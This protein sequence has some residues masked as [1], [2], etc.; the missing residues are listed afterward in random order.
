M[1][2]TYTQL[3]GLIDQA[4]L[5]RVEASLV[6]AAIAISV[7]APG[8]P[9]DVRRDALARNIMRESGL[10]ARN[11]A[12]AV[13]LGFTGG[14]NLTSVLDSAIDTRVA[15]VFNDFLSQT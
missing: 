10:W 8:T 13:A 2:I 5:D 4:W 7:D 3:R 1:A 6:A 14:A 9:L 12:M 15:S 11:F